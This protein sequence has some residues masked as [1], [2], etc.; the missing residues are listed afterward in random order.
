[1]T[2]DEL[3][4]L[5]ELKD[6]ITV[7]ERAHE[8]WERADHIEIRVVDSSYRFPISMFPGL[9]DKV[10]SILDEEITGELIAASHYMEELC[11]CRMETGAPVFTPINVN[12]LNEL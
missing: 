8:V 9:E 1:M 5:N 2:N 6:R 12:E 11:L 10:L 7:L 3:K 4:K